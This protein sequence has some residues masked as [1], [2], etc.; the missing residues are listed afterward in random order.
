MFGYWNTIYIFRLFIYK[1]NVKSL[2][3]II[4]QFIYKGNV[5]LE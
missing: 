3:Y 1:G 4:L 5:I 2:L